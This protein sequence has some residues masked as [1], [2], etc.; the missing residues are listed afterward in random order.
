MTSYSKLQ[1]E[2]RK[3]AD[4]EVALHTRRYFKSGTGEYAEGDKFLGIRMPQIRALVKTCIELDAVVVGKFLQSQWHEER[5]FALLVMVLQFQKG[6]ASEQKK[7]YTKYLDSTVFINNW[8]LTDCSAYQIVGA[9]LSER[10][11]KPLYN[12]ARSQSLWER[13]IAVMATFEFIR[14]DD[15]ADTIA[16]C[17][18]LLQDQEDLIHKVSG[19]MLREIG[20]RDVSVLYGFL[21]QHAASTPRTM[22]RYSIE[23]LSDQKRKHY[24]KF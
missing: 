10:S 9:W 4:P 20:K 1:R 24:M 14:N 6:T 18:M 12:L 19:W 22:L 5:I 7:I 17:E 15:F 3:L 21:D 11:R 2:L 8:D 23:K 13:R 16:L